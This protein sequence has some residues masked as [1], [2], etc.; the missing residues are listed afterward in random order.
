MKKYLILYYSK[1][2]NSEFLAKKMSKELGC[3]LKEIT[4][5]INSI[6]PLF[7]LSVFKIN[8]HTNIQIEDIKQYDEIII[9][10]P[11]WGGL[12]ISPLR[13]VLKKC[14]KAS[15]NIHFVVSCETSE[16]EKNNKYGYQTVLNKTKQIGGNLILSTEAFSTSLIKGESDY[17]KRK[18]S[19]KPKIT[20]NNFKGI[21][22]NKFDEFVKR[23]KRN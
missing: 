2:G 16:E 12:I 21:I 10:G 17:Q 7:I 20:E 13:N 14:I 4:P 19:E 15:K 22:K 11:I 18:L 3:D 1:T 6:I 8:I 5:K 23:I 9:F